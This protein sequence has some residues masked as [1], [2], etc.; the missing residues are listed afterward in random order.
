[1][2]FALGAARTTTTVH[3]STTSINLVPSADASVYKDHP[4]LSY[5]TRDTLEVDGSPIKQIYLQFDVPALAGT[6]THATLTLHVVDSAKQGGDVSTVS[7]NGWSDSITWATRPPIDGPALA[8]IGS[9][10][11]GKDVSVDVTSTISGTGKIT[12]AI[13]S[14]AGDGADYSSRESSHPPVLSIDTS[15]GGT[16]PAPSSSAITPLADATVELSQPTTSFGARHSLEVDNS[17]VKNV[18]LLF[19]VPRYDGQMITKATLTLS[20][21][22]SSDHG[23][24]FF[25]LSDTT[26]SESINWN[27]RPAIDGAQFASLGRV[28]ANTNV[29]VDITSA[30]KGPGLLSLAIT[31]PSSDGADFDS[32]E[33]THAPIL[34]VDTVPLPSLTLPVRAAF[35]YPW[36]PSAWNQQ[37]YDPFTRYVP[38]LGYYDSSDQA[39]IEQQISWM[40]QAGLQAGIASWWG[41]GTPTDVNFHKLLQS[42]NNGFKWAI[43]HEQEGIRDLTQDEIRADLTYLQETAFSDPDYLR[44]DGKPVVFVYNTD[45]TDA[46]VAERW[47]PIA[48]EFNVYLSLKVFAGYRSVTPQPDSWH[49]YAPSSRLDRQSGYSTTISPGFWRIDE[50]NP[51]LARDE[52]AYAN[53]VQQMAAY[54]DPWQLVTSFNEWGEG[55]AIEPSTDWGTRYLQLTAGVPVSSLPAP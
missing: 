36:F 51:R 32:R 45:N 47:V 23:G 15:D 53:A 6:V 40:Q 11:S 1:M 21:I 19:N 18:Y 22:D 31:T 17:P 46:G 50:P 38:T 24:N 8:S 25:T 42:N 43:Y 4:T 29:T 20:V 33:S 28:H 12:V 2:I 41:I 7:N 34:T 13:T 52:T 49:Q 39:V 16:P 27:S 35:Y 55:T 14:N 48:K 44:V 3:A 26:W 30:I 5:G 37:G 10:K 54:N 9:V